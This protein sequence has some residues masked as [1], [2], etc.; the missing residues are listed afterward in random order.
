M[1][2][3]VH[4]AS[5]CA[6]APGEPTVQSVVVSSRL[7]F[8]VLFL[9]RRT[10]ATNLDISGIGLHSGTACR[11]RL[12]AAL[13]GSGIKING[14]TLCH[15]MVKASPLATRLETP[16]GRVN[17]VEHLFAALHGHGIDDVEMEVEG[18]EIPILDGSAEPWR[19]LVE[20]VE[21]PQGSTNVFALQQVVHVGDEHR[22]IRAEPA[23]GLSIDM[24]VNFPQLGAHRYDGTALEWRGAAPARTFGFLSDAERLRTQGL[25]LGASL[26]NT[27]VFHEGHPMNIDGLRFDNEVARHK[28]I[29]LF[30]DLLLL[31]SRLQARVFAYCSGHDL[32]H[33]F[34]RALAG[35]KHG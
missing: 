30:G 14:A 35:L 31:G 19:R 24:R 26:N 5:A 32:H 15:T 7:R 9:N 28:W 22:Y 13:S 29:D 33:E 34:V 6:A 10:L 1:Y 21:Q 16:R 8:G 2:Y 27:L 23:E 12:R 18:F 25:A 20:W 3:A 4:P 17:T 11:V